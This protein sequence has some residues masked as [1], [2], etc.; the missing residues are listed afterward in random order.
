M[1]RPFCC[2]RVEGRPAASIFKPAGI[3][4]RELAEIVM[5]LDEFEAV[6]LA[7]MEGM[8][9]EQAA[10]MMGVSRQTFGRIIGVARGKVADALVNG[11]ALA[12]AGGEGAMEPGSECPRHGGRGGEQCPRRGTTACP[13]YETTG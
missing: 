3:P 8:Y 6:R 12:I 11:K 13:R 2:R 1:P 7:D 9:Q 5:T 10:G 4:A